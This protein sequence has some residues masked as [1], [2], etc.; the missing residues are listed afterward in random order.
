VC[1][2]AFNHKRQ[3]LGVRLFVASLDDVKE[4]R[5]APADPFDLPT[6]HVVNLLQ[7]GDHH[8]G[9]IERVKVRGTVT[10]SRPGSVLYIQEG[11]WGVL[12][13]TSD[14][15]AV[16]LGTVLE[17]EGYPAPGHYSP[18]LENA[19]FRKVGN[20]PPPE[21]I[22][23]SASSMITDVNGFSTA[24]YDALLVR[25]QGRLVEVIPESNEYLLLLR[26]GETIFSAVLPRS[27]HEYRPPATGSVLS[28]TGICAAKA[29]EVH[30]ANS[31]EILLRS[32]ADVVVLE[33]AP[34]WTAR[35][36]MWVAILLV[37]ALVGMSAWVVLIRR[38]VQLRVLS[39]TDPLTGLYN[40]RGFFLFVQHQWQLAIGRKLPILLFYI[41]LDGFKQINDA[42]GHKEG[43]SALKEIANVLREC[44]RK[45][46]IVGRLGGD[47]FAACA[48]D[49]AP[50]TRQMLEQRISHAVQELNGSPD[51]KFQ[52]SL[53]IGVIS[54][55]RTSGAPSL[56]DLLAQADARMFEQ[57][58]RYRARKTGLA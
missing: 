52:F 33:R 51:R 58:K 37:L 11:R 34:W 9:A 31:F 57:K 3:F 41:D 50:E 20:A 13:Q 40:R 24:P 43:D 55:D 48:I 19:A 42:F 28:V 17:V 45:T 8:G 47:E 38:Q 30:D 21:S 46:D 10:Y 23:R 4:E 27:Q 44:F 12:V 26:D 2:T 16:P 15:A 22:P 49:S 35:H 1:G 25:L 53:S 56:E 29:D 39:V 18:T 54:C 32:A 7:F 14:P 36:A 6:R 5:P